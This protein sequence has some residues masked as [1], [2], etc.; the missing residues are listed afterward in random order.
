MFQASMVEVTLLIENPQF[1]SWEDLEVKIRE[2]LMRELGL[3]NMDSV[4]VTFE[5]HAGLTK[6]YA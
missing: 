4:H 5:R 2:T 6:S 1:K 3:E